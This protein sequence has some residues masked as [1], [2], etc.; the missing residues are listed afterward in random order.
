M[1]LGIPEEKQFELAPA[2][3]H[4]ATCYRIIDLG[5]Q[6]FE[7]EGKVSRTHQIIISW[8]L[9]AMMEDGKPFTM[10]K[11]YNYS[12]NEKA[13]LRKD[14]ESWRGLPF[15]EAEMKKFKLCHL[16]KVPC[17]MGV[18][19]ENKGG[20]TRAKASSIVKLPKGMPAPALINPTVDF[21]LGE[22]DQ[23]I[24]DSLPDGIKEKIALSPEYQEIK[25]KRPSEEIPHDPTPDPS[26]YGAS[27]HLNDEI[28]F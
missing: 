7:W 6:Q 19:H 9:A 2:D 8:E 20:K 24:Y 14:L 12:F 3:T 25:G 10:H 26:G 13:N 18:V 4:I 16:F 15:S 5:T 21:D 27:G 28:P 1:S 11:Y 17:L 22:F 23:A